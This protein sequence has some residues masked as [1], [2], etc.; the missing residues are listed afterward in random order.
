MTTLTVPAL[1]AV[2]SPLATNLAFIGRSVKHSLR[3]VDALLM[4]IALPVMLMLVFTYVFGGA[5]ETGGDYINYVVPGIILTCAGFGASSTAVSV[6]TDMTEGIINRFRT[7]P[8]RASAVITGHAVASLLRNL[9]ATGVV[10]VVGLLIGFRP[11]AGPLG[12]LA[13]FGVI[14][15]YILAI[16]WIFAVL[17]LLARSAGAASGYGFGLLFLPYAS[18]AFVPVDTMPAWLRA[19]AEHQPLTPINETIR[20]LLM[21]TPL[22][23]QPWWALGWCLAI[24]I[25]GYLWGR[26]LFPRRLAH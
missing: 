3:E 9:V 25:A 2:P 15:L 20:G 16:T 23:S 18:S 14:A 11:A 13:A 22:G 8:L 1:R 7:M 5:I 21:D 17:G 24:L 12:W 19:F 4:A 10:F 6:N 26:W